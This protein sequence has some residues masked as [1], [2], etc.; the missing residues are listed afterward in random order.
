MKPHDYAGSGP[1]LVDEFGKPLFILKI[2]QDTYEPVSQ[3]A[4]ATRMEEVREFFLRNS[5]GT[6]DLELGNYP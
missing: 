5:D 6:F 4:L 2:Q 3:S 1:P